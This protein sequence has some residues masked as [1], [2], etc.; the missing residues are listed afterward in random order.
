MNA[1]PYLRII[2]NGKRFESFHIAQ[3]EEWRNINGQLNVIAYGP[4]LKNYRYKFEYEES[5]GWFALKIKNV[6]E[7][8]T[9]IWQCKIKLK[10]SNS[11]VLHF[12][13]RKLAKIHQL[14]SEVTLA[15]KMIF[16]KNEKEN[17]TVES[18]VINYSEPPLFRSVQL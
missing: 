4:E 14:P 17:A 13:S 6:T 15:P 7:E 3:V 5:R 10:L 1:D 12:E 8:E 16:A 18:Q 9:G 2:S 11:T